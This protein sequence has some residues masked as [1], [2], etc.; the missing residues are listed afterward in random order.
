MNCTI[1]LIQ[2]LATKL[3]FNHFGYLNSTFPS[4]SI[5]YVRADSPRGFHFPTTIWDFDVST[6]PG[7]LNL[8]EL[9]PI[10]GGDRLTIFKQP[11]FTAFVLFHSC[12]F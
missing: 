2:K 7:I 5:Q 6:V 10:E 11:S 12:F 8:T 3:D 9:D 1:G 4:I